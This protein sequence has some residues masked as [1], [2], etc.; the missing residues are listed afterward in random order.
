MWWAL[1]WF[2]IY[3]PCVLLAWPFG[4]VAQ[5]E[6]RRPAPLVRPQITNLGFVGGAQPPISPHQFGAGMTNQ[7]GAGMTNQFGA[8]M[9]PQFGAGMTHQFGAGMTNQF[10]AGMTNQI[11]EVVPENEFQRYV[12][13]STGQSLPLF[14]RQLFS[15]RTAQFFPEFNVPV[16]ADYVIGPGDELIVRA[17]GNID[18]NLRLIVDR[19][20]AINV[21]QVGVLQ[22]AG[23][24]ADQVEGFI[25][26]QVGRLFQNFEMNVTFGRL[27]SIKVLIVGHAHKP[28]N[29]AISSL[30]TAMSALFMAGGPSSVGSMRKIEVRR[31]GQLVS[32]LDLYDLLLNGNNSGDV[33]LAH[34]DIIRVSPLGP[35]VALSGSVQLPAV[36]ELAGEE[37]LKDVIDY[38]GGLTATA[39]RGRVTLERI[40]NNTNRKIQTM[41]LD[42]TGLTQKLQNGDI[43][44]VEPISPEFDQIVSLR[45][46]VDIPRRFAWKAGMRIKDLIPH[47]NYLIPRHYWRR[48]NR[49]SEEGES[50]DLDPARF[51]RRLLSEVN[52][53]YATITRLNPKTLANELIVFNLGAAIQQN[54]PEENHLLRPGDVITIY[55]QEDVGVPEAHKDILV[56][57]RGE[58]S[59]PGVYRVQPGE[60][61]AQL[62][63][64]VGGFTESA[65]AYASVFTRR[66]VQIE[67]QKRLDE[68]VA[69]VEKELAQAS[70]RMQARALDKDVQASLEAQAAARAKSIATMRETVA[71]GRITLNL[72]INTTQ[73]KALP[74]VELKDGDVFFVPSRMSEVHIMGEVFNQQS[75]IWTKESTVLDVMAGAGGPTRYADMKQMF[76]IRANGKVESYRQY[77]KRFIHT[78]LYAGDTLVVPEEIDTA[79]WRFELKEWVKIFSD[80]ALGAAAIRVLSSD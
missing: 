50:D 4:L 39:Y 25:K 40:E 1:R 77:E 18:I 15:P 29:Y 66:S 42:Q 75:S 27:R 79:N 24:K 71:T 20:G 72:P 12:T 31:G 11:L 16:T 62:V 43:I 60:T 63:D 37:Q 28:G 64:R 7:F 3:G 57:L 10:G 70:A 33:R 52:W 32:T 67:Q 14:G 34:G 76:I 65:Y 13:E 49:L 46:H 53:Q 36:Y 47:N 21:P 68:G 59:K 8:G 58:V 9:T 56:T 44:T 51:A 45:G 26:S 74:A 61:L 55:S 2:R 38:S 48:L 80:F 5:P 6:L 41:A 73:P 69:R 78:R 19:D 22:V 54:D 30:S 17:W 23:L 35:M